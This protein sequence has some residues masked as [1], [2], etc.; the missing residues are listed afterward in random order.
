MKV[1]E[2]IKT[3]KGG[4]TLQIQILEQNSGEIAANVSILDPEKSLN[5]RLDSEDLRR[6]GQLIGDHKKD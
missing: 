4:Y 1:L 6:I 2:Q 5:I 3:T